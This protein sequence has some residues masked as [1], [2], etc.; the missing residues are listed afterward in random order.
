MR[1]RLPQDRWVLALKRML[2]LIEGG[3]ALHSEDST[4]IGNKYT[5]CTWG[6]CFESRK[7]WPDA[8]DHLWPDEFTKRGRIAP[9][10]RDRGQL[11]PMDLRARDSHAVVLLTPP[12]GCFYSCSVFQATKTKRAPTREQTIEFYKLAIHRAEEPA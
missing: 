12:D 2:G 9:L 8:E 5:T 6:M 11:C 7:L 3:V 4:E 10:Y 1:T